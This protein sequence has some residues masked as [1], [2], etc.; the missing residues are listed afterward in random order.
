MANHLE[1]L[2]DDQ[3]RNVLKT[4]FNF[5]FGPITPSTR[6]LYVSKLLNLQNERTKVRPKLRKVINSSRVNSNQKTEIHPLFA[7]NSFANDESLLF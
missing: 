7:P 3:L 6:Y 4:E 1:D 2:T 5:K